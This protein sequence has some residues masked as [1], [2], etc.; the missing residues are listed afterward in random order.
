MLRL[1][2][3]IKSETSKLLERR[4]VILEELKEIDVGLSDNNIYNIDS[5]IKT[6]E[7]L[8][9]KIY[10]TPHILNIVGIRRDKVLLNKFN[11]IVLVFWY[12]DNKDLH[13]R[14]WDEFTTLPGRYYLLNPI[15]RKGTGIVKADM[16]Y[17]DCYTYE[18]HRGK[19]FALT[20]RG[21]KVASYRDNN[22]DT[23]FDL[24]EETID[25][26]Y[27]GANIHKAGW[28]STIVNKW[29][30]MCQVFGRATDF[31]QF[32][33]CV[34]DLQLK[35]G[36]KHTFTYTLLNQKTIDNVTIKTKGE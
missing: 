16:Q 17:V 24:N 33:W 4:K 11:D 8:K 30:A 3:Y 22:R 15:N 14:I 12:D 23:T 10:T 18:K 13:Y 5:V 21:G 25:W 36:K 7:S 35:K 31:K 29:S 2:H 19:Y 27:H 20:Q 32:M 26:G 34:T 9:F 6:L 1:P 28:L